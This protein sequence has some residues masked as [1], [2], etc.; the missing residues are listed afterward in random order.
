[1]DFLTAS[2]A[3]FARLWFERGLAGLYAIAFLSALNQFPALLGERGLLPVPE[4]LRHRRFRHAPSLF[5]WHY[6]DRLMKAVAMAG[7]ALSVAMAAGAFANMPLGVAMI[8]WLVMWFLYQS[9]VNVGQ[10]F[11]SFGWESMILEAGF[12][13]AFLG[14]PW[15][16]P[17]IFPV[18]IL[19][20]MLF[21]TELGA[22]LIKLRAGGCWLDRTALDHHHETQP[23]PNPLSRT[24]HHLPRW[25]LHGGVLF[26]HFVQ[27]VVPFGLFLPQPVA[28]C[29]ALLM[30]FHQLLLIIAGNY[31]WLNWLTIVLAFIALP[32]NWLAPMSPAAPAGLT[33]RPLYWD[34]TLIA[35]AVWTLWLSIAPARNLCSK[36]QRM[37]YCWNRWHLVNAYGAFGTV[38]KERYEVVV[39]GTHAEDPLD[40]RQEWRTYE[41][42]GKPTRLSRIP[43]VFAPY[44]L[45]LDWLMWFLPFSVIVTPRGLLRR[46]EEPWF[47][48]FVEKLLESDPA[49]T[50]LLKENPFPDQPPLYVRA[51]FFLYQFTTRNEKKESGDVWKRT[52]VGDYL[53]PTRLHTRS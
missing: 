45:R 11:Y 31:A 35:L 14:P 48:A 15:M 9:I 4:F 22:G 18:L 6:S 34:V 32:G 46:G 28:G 51:R 13:A 50:K 3:W 40:S 33:P 41:F 12:F 8:A 44:H 7:I 23:M 36:R 5:H 27:V 38:T 19:R 2:D 42:K 10:T 47:A 37:N 17:S 25:M 20:W 26:S 43:G 49:V 29:A 21:R 39:E 52:Y 53:K 16:E 1:M 30:I 24:V